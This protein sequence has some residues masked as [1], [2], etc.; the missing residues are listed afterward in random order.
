MSPKTLVAFLAGLVVASGITFYVMRKPQPAAQPAPAQRAMPAAQSTPAPPVPAAPAS[1][2]MASN[3]PPTVEEA[4]PA[5]PR[6]VNA[7]ARTVRHHEHPQ[8][9][10]QVQAAPAPVA[11]TPAPVQ[12]PGPAASQQQPAAQPEPTTVETRNVVPPPPAP[13]PAEPN[14]VTIPVGTTFQVRIGETLSTERNKDGDAFVATLDQPLVV[15]G[16][17]IAER[18]ARVRGR[19]V[20]ALRSGRVEGLAKLSVQL[21]EVNT[22]D[23][24]RL[25]VDTSP[26][27]RQAPTTHKADAAKIGGGAAL[28]AIIGAIAGGG[29]G[30][31]IGAGVGGA[32]GTG[33]VMMTR[34]KPAEIPVETRVAFRLKNP[35]T[36]TEQLH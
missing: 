2:A 28:G 9:I 31:A 25:K 36:I 20:Q 1:D 8:V 24:Q 13:P 29:K 27:E 19:V 35:V 4:A 5:Q 30:A 32:A 23:G 16:F 33:G 21:T 26:F 14:S 10:A 7:P 6:H 3:V 34:G 11:A 22:S 15:D 12:Q 17:V 18:G